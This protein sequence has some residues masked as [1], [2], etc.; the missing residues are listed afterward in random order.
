MRTHALITPMLALVLSACASFDPARYRTVVSETQDPATW[1]GLPIENGQIILNE[2]RGAA[3][4]FVSFTAGKFSQY[5]HAGVIVFDAGTPYV[6]ESFGRLV[7]L[8]WRR[9]NEHMGGGVRRVSLEAFLS[10]GGIVA[11]YAPGPEIDRESLVRFAR[12]RM[13]EHKA[14]DGRYDADDADRYYCVEF[15]ARALEAAGSAP[16]PATPVS[17]NPSMQVALGWLGIGTSGL[18]LAD[19][20]VARYRR[21]VLLSEHDSAAGISRYFGLKRELHRRFT[22][23][24]RLGNVLY[25]RWQSLRLRPSVDAYFESGLEDDRDPRVL[26]DAMFGPADQPSLRGSRAARRLPRRR[27]CA[28]SSRA[29]A[30]PC[31]C[32]PGRGS[33]S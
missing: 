23:D 22:A 33:P 13:R 26:A 17:R 9:P 5:V 11:I 7:P 10:R 12:E 16:I 8:P 15:V 2:H 29:A 25:W 6:Y 24:Q 1:R 18:L 19:D 30:G 21:V 27:T 3:S 32:R 20:L 28:P 31:G 14:F 4:L